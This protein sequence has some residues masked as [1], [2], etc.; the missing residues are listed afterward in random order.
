M[1]VDAVQ[2]APSHTHSARHWLSAIQARWSS[3]FRC[4]TT[5]QMTRTCLLHAGKVIPSSRP[6]SRQCN[7]HADWKQRRGRSY[8]P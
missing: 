8:C 5:V 6:T 3:Q 2:A 1:E 7:C 4:N